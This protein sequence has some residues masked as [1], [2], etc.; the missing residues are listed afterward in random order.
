MLDKYKIDSRYNIRESIKQ[1]DNNGEG[2]IFVVDKSDKV[3][4][5]VTDGDFRRAIL[6]EVSLDENCMSIANKDFKYVESDFN[7]REIINIFLHN[8]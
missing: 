8:G 2:F 3:V 5:L 4:G 1:I 6:N 7:E